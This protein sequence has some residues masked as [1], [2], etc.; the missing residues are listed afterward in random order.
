MGT[1]ASSLVPAGVA[2]H[3]LDTKTNTDLQHTR[4]VVNKFESMSEALYRHG[5]L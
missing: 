4:T 2:D 3:A 1:G 5:L